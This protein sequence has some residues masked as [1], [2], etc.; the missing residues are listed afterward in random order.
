MLP[1]PHFSSTYVTTM[2]SNAN[3]EGRAAIVRELQEA[4]GPTDI[5]TKTLFGMLGKRNQSNQVLNHFLDNRKVDELL[6]AYEV[7]TNYRNMIDEKLQVA[8]EGLLKQDADS[9]E[10]YMHKI[11]QLEAAKLEM[12]SELKKAKR[13]IYQMMLNETNRLPSK[14]QR[15]SS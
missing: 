15:V 13:S 1:W 10:Q 7:L 14:R 8:Y 6:R 3:D 5:I 11:E 4:A 9:I 2:S 12:S